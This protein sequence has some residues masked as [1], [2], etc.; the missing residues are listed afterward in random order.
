M[1]SLKLHV[2]LIYWAYFPADV[3]DV[4]ETMFPLSGTPIQQKSVP[5]EI[6]LVQK[7]TRPNCSFVHA[8]GRVE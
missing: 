6:V 4:L 3:N 8:R 2:T 7:D 5:V 1:E